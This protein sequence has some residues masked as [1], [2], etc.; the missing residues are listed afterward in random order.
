MSNE[1]ANIKHAGHRYVKRINEHH[2]Y[3]ERITETLKESTSRLEQ[4]SRPHT[5]NPL[6]AQKTYSYAQ[7]VYSEQSVQIRKRRF[8]HKISICTHKPLRAHKLYTYVQA[9][10]HEKI[11]QP[12]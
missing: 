5:Q 9:T 12:T 7:V 1:S 10:L 11:V 4:T 2:R 3:V 6:Y 8:T